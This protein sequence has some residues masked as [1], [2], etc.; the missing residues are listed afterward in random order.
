MQKDYKKWTPVKIATNNVAHRPTY[1]EGG[2]YWVLI[3]DNVGM[4]QDGKGELFAR[5]VVIVKGFS[6]ELFWGIPLTSRRKTG[7][8]YFSFSFQNDKTSTAILS[9]LRAF[10][11]SRISGPSIGRIKNEDL[12]EIKNRLKHLL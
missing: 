6:K 7:T 11:T 12:I 5:P 3:G 1:K 9:Q 8:Y 4:E 2:I 10:D